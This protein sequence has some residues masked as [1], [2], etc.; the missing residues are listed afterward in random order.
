MQVSHI[1]YLLPKVREVEEKK[2]PV[3]KKSF[4]YV[5]GGFNTFA[6]SFVVFINL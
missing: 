6:F 1:F 4:H 5:I 2:G 3:A